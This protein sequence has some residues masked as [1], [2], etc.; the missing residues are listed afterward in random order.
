MLGL[1][2]IQM[3]LCISETDSSS[4]FSLCISTSLCFFVFLLG[5]FG[6]AT[7]LCSLHAQRTPQALGR[8]HGCLWIDMSSQ[9]LGWVE[10]EPP[11]HHRDHHH[12]QSLAYRRVGSHKGPPDEQ[13]VQEGVGR[14]HRVALVVD[15]G[16]GHKGDS[17]KVGLY[18][19]HIRT[20]VQSRLGAVG[21]MQGGAAHCKGPRNHL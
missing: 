3:L 20:G 18:L 14:G 1:H 13:R 10:L 2:A 9:C 17:D 21:H 11:T 4:A 7:H 12:P 8:N 15:T 16:L 19:G 6:S 5:I